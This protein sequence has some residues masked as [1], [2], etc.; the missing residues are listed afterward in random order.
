[1]SENCTGHRARPRSVLS[2]RHRLACSLSDIV[3]GYTSRPTSCVSPFHSLTCPH[4]LVLSFPTAFLA[5]TP[6]LPT[7][8][9]LWISLILPLPNTHLT[10]RF[11]QRRA[12]SCLLDR[13]GSGLVRPSHFL[14]S[15][16]ALRTLST[17]P[18]TSHRAT[19]SWLLERT[20][21]GRSVGRPTREAQVQDR[22]MPHVTLQVHVLYE[23]R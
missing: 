17:Q 22:L 11:V 7:S 15:V 5:T 13:F 16:P 6:H 9:H 12:S 4:F 10:S 23:S 19:N 21:T 20:N 18:T 2:F 8:S 3:S 14:R 1:M